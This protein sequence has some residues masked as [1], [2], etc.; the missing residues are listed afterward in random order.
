MSAALLNIYHRLPAW[1]RSSAVRLH[2][3]HLRSWRF[4]PETPKLMQEAEERDHWTHAQWE[5]WRQE[6]LS[7][8]LHRAATRVPYYRE[9][10]AERRRQGDLSSWTELENWPILD[11][12]AVR[13][14]PRDFV[15][16]DCDPKRMFYGH[17]S[18]TTGTPIDLWR[19]RTTM[20][21]LYALSASRTRG[22][23]G[24]EN[25]DRWAKLG[26]QVVTPGHQKEPPF[27]VWNG[28]LNQL[29]M[30]TYHL[31]PNLIGHYLDALVAH[32]IEYLFG[33]TSSVFA[34][35]QEMVRLKRTDIKLK[36]VITEAEPLFQHQRRVIE[37]AFQCSVRETY[38]MGE[39]V[40]A[41]SECGSGTLHQWPEIGHVEVLGKGGMVGDGEFGE[42]VCTSLLNS[43]MPL[44]RYRVGDRGRLL[45]DS[46]CDCGRGLPAIEVVEAG[47]YDL[48]IT[49]DGRRILGLEDVFFNTPIREAQIVQER[50][51][52]IR[53]RYVPAAGFTA[54]SAR[55]IV[56]AVQARMKGVEVI[57]E[58]VGE[59][60]RAANGKFWLQVCNVPD[61]EIQAVL[62]ASREVAPNPQ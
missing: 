59:I 14:R 34:L 9:L 44:I 50:L 32:R 18:G 49:Q 39:Q 60:P 8:V 5:E 36:V 20:R 40:T 3:L 11:K 47:S 46:P 19:S 56:K 48:L 51:D 55:S 2:G 30:S 26:G 23:H 28:A 41:G 61:A 13:S 45:V 42:L 25:N 27:W 10:W 22:W 38:G 37:E 4:G 57:L 35:A 7:S 17:T 21:T 31:A 53:A 29:Y 43:D 33:Y 6:R 1:M 24:V 16:D 15:A 52:L 12:E 58:P 54:E 62:A